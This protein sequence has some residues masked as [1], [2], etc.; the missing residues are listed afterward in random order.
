MNILATN[1]DGV[2]SPAL[3]PLVRGLRGLGR[4]QV[5]APD[6]ERSWSGKHLS[7]LERIPVT[8]VTRD[9]IEMLAVGGSPADATQIG[10]HRG[11]PPDLVVSGINLGSNHGSAFLM[12]SGTV[13]AAVEGEL[14]GHPAI[15]LSVG[16]SEGDFMAWH[17]HVRSP[18]GASGWVRVTEVAMEIVADVLATNLLDHCDIVSVNMPWEVSLTT[19]RDITRVAR[20]RYGAVYEP[21]TVDD[22]RRVD[23]SMAITAPLHVNAGAT[24][25]ATEFWR[26]TFTELHL[27]DDDLDGT[28]IGAAQRGHVSITPVRLPHAAAVP[29]EVSAA[30]SGRSAG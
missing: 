11:L 3:P 10:C 12:T 15:A 28:D 5:V 6:G 23:T 17:R 16:I 9:G 30:M 8:K 26:P 7:R 4:V 29:D 2:D 24:T 25:D 27:L 20:T 14:S 21:T 22:E 13:G 1:D 18:D 19:P